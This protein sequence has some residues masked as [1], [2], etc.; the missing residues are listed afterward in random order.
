MAIASIQAH[1]IPA[2]AAALFPTQ[3][4]VVQLHGKNRKVK[5]TAAEDTRLLDL[6]QQLGTKDWTVISSMMQTRNPRQ[7]RERYNNYLNPE[8]RNDSWTPEEDALLESKYEELGAKW[9]RIGRFFEN[10]S[11]NALR[12]RSMMLSRHHSKDPDASAPIDDSP[13]AGERHRDFI[14]A[15][16]PTTR[17]DNLKGLENCDD[18]FDPWGHFYF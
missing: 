2:N 1:V 12:N 17:Y 9:S 10:R 15:I 3:R 8:L 13:P 18:R 4:D 7:C 14:P 6:V 5:F 11:D 16:G